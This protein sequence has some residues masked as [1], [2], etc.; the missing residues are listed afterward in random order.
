MVHYRSGH[1]T[2]EID[3]R[4]ELV[5]IEPGICFPAVLVENL[6]AKPKHQR[7]MGARY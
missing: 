4:H 6:C 5:Q 3:Q 2:A 1:P 7:S